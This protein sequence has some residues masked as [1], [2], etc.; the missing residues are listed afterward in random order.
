MLSGIKIKLAK[1]YGGER[2]KTLR[3][4]A[5]FLQLLLLYK[6]LVISFLDHIFRSLLTFAP[7]CRTMPK[8]SS[9]LTE[10]RFFQSLKIRSESFVATFS[11]AFVAMSWVE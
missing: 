11:E 4:K 5:A 7:P 6:S 2:N 1:G 8:I 3:D 10:F 9:C